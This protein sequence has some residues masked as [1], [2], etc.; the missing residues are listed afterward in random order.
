MS[1]DKPDEGAIYS[2]L[3]KIGALQ[4]KVKQTGWA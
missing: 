3:D 2:L 1:A 4:T